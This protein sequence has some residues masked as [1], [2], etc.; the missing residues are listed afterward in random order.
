MISSKKEY[1]EY[2]REDRIA[3]NRVDRKFPMTLFD[4]PLRYQLVLR[5][6]EYWTNCKTNLFSKPLVLFFQLRHRIIGNKCGYSIP[7]NVCGKGLNLAHLGTVI[8]N[9]GAQ[10]GEYCRIH[11]GV[12]IGTKAGESNSAPCIGNRVYIGPGAKL[13]G[14][15]IVGDDTA[16]GAN[17]VVTKSFEQGNITLAGVPARIIAT[18]GS[19][20]LLYSPV[21]NDKYN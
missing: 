8:I 19:Q 20:G 13:F 15:I 3:L 18:K 17:A 2:V 9:S 5:R 11:A 4:L 21:M 12:N 7:L 1:L 6:A 10:I 14:H 16:I